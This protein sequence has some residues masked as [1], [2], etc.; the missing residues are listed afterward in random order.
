ME[1][2]ITSFFTALLAAFLGAYVALYKFK[3]EKIWEK[4]YEAYQEILTALNNMLLWA[5]ETYSSSLCLP[6]IAYK[7]REEVG[8]AHSEA[9][10]CI[11]KYTTIGELL[12]SDEVVKILEEINQA[13][14]DEDFRF[15]DTGMDESNY[16]EELAKHAENVTKTL[17]D[18]TKK[19]VT[20][21]K[22]DLK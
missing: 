14:W 3:R 12:V 22:K 15:D 7:K 19:L 20:L 13:L 2:L 9:R 18:R 6:T 1:Q 4:K 8:E 10:Q 11:L 16:N 21:A 5:N 17:S